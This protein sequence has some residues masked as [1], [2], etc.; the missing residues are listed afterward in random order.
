M[1][2]QHKDHCVLK[3]ITKKPMY[4]LFYR[5][6]LTH[7]WIKYYTTKIGFQIYLHLEKSNKNLLLQFEIF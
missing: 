1:K 4:F 6:Y 2:L 3:G 7:T 5:I